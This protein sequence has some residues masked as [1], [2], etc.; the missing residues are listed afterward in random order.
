[1]IRL[2]SKIFDFL[3]KISYGMYVLHP[4]VIVLL[5]VPLKHIIPLITGKPLQIAVIALFVIPITILFAW[6]SFRYF[7]LRF[8][9]RKEDFSR[10]QSTNDKR[11][12]KPSDEKIIE[13]GAMSM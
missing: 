7:E 4:F 1:M 3:G 5:A 6:L 2:K 13:A 10:V 9:K 12:L 11:E 8:L